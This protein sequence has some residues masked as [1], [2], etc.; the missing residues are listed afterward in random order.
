MTNSDFRP[1]ASLENLKKRADVIR[2]IRDFFDSRGFFHVETPI[3]S[4]DTVVDRYLEPISLKKPKVTGTDSKEARLWLQTSPEFGMK[5]LLADG[6][7]AIYQITRAF[8]AEE[9]GQRHNP[10]IHDARMV[11]RRRIDAGSDPVSWWIC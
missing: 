8:R 7:E 4:H 3:L 6:A 9:A 1:T 11:S 5:R 10:G 2:D